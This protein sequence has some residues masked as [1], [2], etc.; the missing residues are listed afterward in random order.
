MIEGKRYRKILGLKEERYTSLQV[1]G[2]RTR[3]FTYAKGELLI[4]VS[5]TKSI[6]SGKLTVQNSAFW[7]SRCEVKDGKLELGVEKNNSGSFRTASIVL[8]YPGAE[9][10]TLS[11]KQEYSSSS[12]VCSPSYQEV[13]N[14][15]GN[16]SF[17]YSIQN[18]Q[19]CI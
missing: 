3:S 10:I 1:E 12:I 13:G 7:V 15:G 14:D 17:T 8:A 19:N 16:Y 5:V 2:E 9:N 11:V 4:P 18:H 6:P